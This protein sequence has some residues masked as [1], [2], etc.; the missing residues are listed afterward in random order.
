MLTVSGSV[1]TRYLVRSFLTTGTV[2]STE[3]N[4]RRSRNHYDSIRNLS[5]QLS[6]DRKTFFFAFM[7]WQSYSTSSWLSFH[8]WS[9]NVSYLDD[10]HHSSTSQIVYMR[11]FLHNETNGKCLL[12]LSALSWNWNYLNKNVDVCSL[13]SRS[14]IFYAVISTNSR[15]LQ[16]IRN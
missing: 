4:W 14:W 3:N 2:P 10:S 8:K 6:I 9:S 12:T 11:V 16:L 1:G 13:T 7:H 15:V 5:S